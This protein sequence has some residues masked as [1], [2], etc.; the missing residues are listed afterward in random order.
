[1]IAPVALTWLSRVQ[2][3][4]RPIFVRE[5][6]ED[7]ELFQLKGGPGRE[8]PDWDHSWAFSAVFPT[9]LGSV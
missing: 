8:F 5:D 9:P 4:G 2:I 1:M 3:D 6:R 7:Y